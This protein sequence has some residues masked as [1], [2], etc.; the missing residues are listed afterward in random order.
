MNLLKLKTFLCFVLLVTMF[1]CMTEQKQINNAIDPANMDLAYTP[2]QDFYL[3]ANGT[4]INE[5]P[6]PE[7]YTQYGAFTELREK[8]REDLK[9]L[10]LE[11]AESSDANPE[12]F[13]RR[14]VIFTILE[15]IP[16][17]LMLQE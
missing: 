1:S 3:Y 2:G 5:N 17:L 16:L 6:L 7:E 13:K 10:V 11:S 15:W 12:V 14:S 8:N 9:K 4:W